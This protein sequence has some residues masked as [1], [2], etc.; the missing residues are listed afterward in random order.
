MDM[1]V[2]DY[3]EFPCKIPEILEL[4]EGNSVAS[5]AGQGTLKKINFSDDIV[6]DILVKL[7]MDGEQKARH[8]SKILY[9]LQKKIGGKF[10]ELNMFSSP[11]N[12]ETYGGGL[13]AGSVSFAMA[14]L[15][16]DKKETIPQLGYDENLESLCKTLPYI[17]GWR[18]AIIDGSMPRNG[19]LFKKYQEMKK[20]VGLD[21]KE[22]EEVLYFSAGRQCSFYGQLRV[23]GCVVCRIQEFVNRDCP[24]KFQKP[25]KKRF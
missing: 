21:E 22:A 14:Y 17:I 10:K 16:E 19:R 3:L 12:L 20:S 11:H 24:F 9:P 23:G 5:E 13:T 6:D 1:T 7:D 25:L 15:T 18:A 2:D 4:K 8:V